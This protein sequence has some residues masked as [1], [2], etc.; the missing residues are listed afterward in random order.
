[1]CH[2]P[3]SGAGTESTAAS[4]VEV[5]AGAARSTGCCNEHHHHAVDEIERAR[6]SRRNASIG[7]ISAVAA[8][9]SPRRCS[10]QGGPSPKC[11]R[12]RTPLLDVRTGAVRV[13]MAAMSGAC[14]PILLVMTVEA[15]RARMPSGEPKTDAT[16]DRR[17]HRPCRA[18][19]LLSG[20][21]DRLCDRDGRRGR[22]LDRGRA[23]TAWQWSADAVDNVA[24][25]D[26]WWCRCF[27]TDR[28]L[29]RSSRIAK[30]ALCHRRWCSRPSAPRPAIGDDHRLRGSARCRARSLT[31]AATMTE[32]RAMIAAT[33][34]RPG[35][36]PAPSRGSTLVS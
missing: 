6:C 27:G 12:R 8:S 7:V 26:C 18:V 5:A 20:A 10:A 13:F 31:C 3:L 28:R 30:R 29:S 25:Y 9:L 22:I 15:V 21:S 16:I 24:D 11:A 17:H 1:M 23:R 14:A 19:T 2:S 35:L 33:A 34:M 4:G 36:R 32:V